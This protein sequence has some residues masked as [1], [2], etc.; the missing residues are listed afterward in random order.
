[1][2]TLSLT[3]FAS[4]NGDAEFS[5]QL[6][7]AIASDPYFSPDAHNVQIISRENE[8]ILTGKVASKAEKDKI[9]KL[10]KL[11]ESK[12]RIFNGLTY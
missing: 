7:V 3:C 6:K 10:V 8:I 9:E 1:M 4:V 2:L 11:Q 12:R 5:R